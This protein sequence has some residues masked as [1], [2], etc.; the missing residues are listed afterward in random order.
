MA[1]LR[2]LVVDDEP[3]ARLRLVQL[4]QELDGAPGLP[5]LQLV[6]EAA[7]A[8]AALARLDAAAAAAAAG[9]D[10]GCDLLLLDI[11]LPGPDGLKLADAL[12][13]RPQPPAV[14]FVTAH[15]EHAL[16]AFEVDAA[17]YLTKPVRRDRLAAALDRVA[18]RRVPSRPAL[19]SAGSAAVLVV[20]H[21]G[22]VLRLP[23]DELLW[24]KAE[25]KLV[26]V[27][28]RQ[29]QWSLDESLAELEPRLGPGFLRVHRNAI[30]A[31]AAARALERSAPGDEGEGDGAEAWQLRLADGSRLAVSRRQLAAVK[32][33][34]AA[35]G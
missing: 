7:D 20:N 5:P 6:G 28:T 11:N 35:S 26:Q 18:Q 29:G 23:L 22:R 32:A 34:L 14:V 25:A 2:I 13:R 27:A 1:P 24:L 16:R 30:V 31:L 10:G 9:N 3:Y 8:E 15:A 17:D 19:A 33:A 4:L 21:R 12:R